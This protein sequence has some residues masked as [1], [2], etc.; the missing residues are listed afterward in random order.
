MLLFAAYCCEQPR[1]FHAAYCC[2]QPRN[3]HAALWLQVNSQLQTSNADVYAVGD[4]AAFPLV[5]YDNKVSRQ[6][7]V[8][9][10]RYNFLP[11]WLLAPQTTACCQGIC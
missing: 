9:N 2:E 6:E 1:N 10:A 7:H 8:V 4:I 5:M 3:C 11:S